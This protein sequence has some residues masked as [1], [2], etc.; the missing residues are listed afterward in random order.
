[1]TTLDEQLAET[2]SLMKWTKDAKIRQIGI[3]DN[4]IEALVDARNAHC[5]V[6]VIFSSDFDYNH[7]GDAGEFELRTSAAIR[8]WHLWKDHLEERGITLYDEEGEPVWE[9]DGNVFVAVDD[10]CEFDFAGLMVKEGLIVYGTGGW[11]L[12][13]ETGYPAV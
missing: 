5:D 3:L 8:F 1:M 12:L 6:L 11:G 13:T 2:Q 4:E 7:F 10:H 9:E